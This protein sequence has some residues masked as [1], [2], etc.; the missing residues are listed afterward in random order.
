MTEPNKP[1]AN[2]FNLIPGIGPI[3]LSRI[4]NNFPDL[5]A[6]WSGAGR[7]DLENAGLEPKTVDSI[8]NSRPK[9][10]PINEYG[11]M[12]RIGI[13][14]L[15][16]DEDSYPA[17]LKEIA[18]APPILYIRGN[19]AIL[20]RMAVGAV[21]TRKLTGYG[22]QAIAHLI[23]GLAAAGINV[24]SGLAFGADAEC[25]DTALDC[26]LSPVA[27]LATSLEDFN[28]S[29]RSNFQLA[30]RIIKTGCLVSEYP[31]G[32]QT[33]KQNFPVRNRLISGLSA[34]V[35]VIEAAEDSGSLITANYALDQ[36][37]SVFAVP[38]EIFSE[39]SKGTNKLLKRG[40]K[41]VTQVS[42]IL[43]EFNL[44]LRST[45]SAVNLKADSEAEKLALSALVGAKS[46]DELVIETKLPGPQ[47]GV[48]LSLLE[49]NGRIKNLGNGKY[50]KIA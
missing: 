40:A 14:A 13:Q 9:I 31:L 5:Q 20:G 33:S 50:A 38:G 32:S 8:I 26:G 39:A 34:G 3:R 12:S 19:P 4:I 36:N 35:L 45:N 1:F 48:A 28:I 46:F 6:A 24:V 30:M 21:G 18:G 15:F 2:A 43:E 41:L 37:R 17:L 10:D 11:K 25:L 29:P 23:P 42:D 49:L 22:R 44:D 27:V 7:F 47:L 16:A